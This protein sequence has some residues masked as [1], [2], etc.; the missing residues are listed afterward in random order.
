MGRGLRTAA[1]IAAGLG[2]VAMA[3]PAGADPSIPASYF[4]GSTASPATV[5]A[6][7]PH[8]ASTIPASLHWVPV[9]AGVAALAEVEAGALEIVTGVGNPPVVGAI[10]NGVPLDVLWVDSLTDTTLIVSPS[11]K[12]PSALA[13]KSVA[14]L[15]GSSTDYE[16]R[17]WLSVEHLTN[18]A[19][20]VG[21]AS[22]QAAASAFLAG[23]VAG[24]Y[25]SG[26]LA[27]ELLDH[28]GHRLTDA[29]KIAAVG[30]AG[31]N[32]LA[33]ST[34]LIKSN[35]SLVQKY[36]CAQ[37]TATNDMLG[38]H[39]DLYFKQSAGLLG[40][41]ATTAIQAGKNDVPYLIK[42]SQERK[43]LEGSNG[44]SADG[45]LVKSYVKTASFDLAQGRIASMPSTAAIAAHVD[46][47]FALNA[48]R[49]HCS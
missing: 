9:T 42:P 8:L 40:A 39:Q 28:G 35:P 16:V 34:T 1:L 2:A 19:Q 18:S 49:G 37:L 11:I 15:E 21:F 14:D 4:T 10:G 27:L 12:S 20:V 32:V 48:L 6:T 3:S 44:K 24:A 45:A 38:P 43:W 33:V 36:V 23:K 5:I 31:T 25:V 17:G 29:K 41:K 47:K 7:N 13:G 46:P 26:A 30:Y 22:Q